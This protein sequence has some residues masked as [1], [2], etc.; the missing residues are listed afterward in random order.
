MLKVKSFNTKSHGKEGI[1]YSAINTWNRLQKQ[2]KHFLL[3]NLTT[4][5]LKNFLKI[6]YLKTY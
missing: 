1:I 2:L 6:H 3:R 5:Q 4:F